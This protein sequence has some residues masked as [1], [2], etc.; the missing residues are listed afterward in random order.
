MKP[1]KQMSLE[2]ND[3]SELKISWH[4]MFELQNMGDVL[5]GGNW[6]QKGR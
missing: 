4:K 2:S 6:H 3:N 5:D 1:F